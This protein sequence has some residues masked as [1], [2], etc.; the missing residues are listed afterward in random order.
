MPSIMPSRTRTKGRSIV[1]RYGIAAASVAAATLGRFA[2]TPYVGT[3]LPYVVFYFA[4]I[5]VASYLG[6]GPALVA[7]ALAACSAATFF[8]KPFTEFGVAMVTDLIGLALFVAVD[9]VIVGFAEANRRARRGLELEVAERVRAEATILAQIS[10]AEFGRDIGLALTS[11][12]TLAEV[13]DRCAALTI[14][15]LG[16]DRARIATLDELGVKATADEPGREPAADG[17][18]SPDSLRG[19]VGR[20][21]TERRAYLT[22]RLGEDSGVLARSWAIRDDMIA[23]AGCPLVVE[24]RLI[25]VWT[26]LSRTPLDEATTAAMDSAATVL[27]V[28]IE[29]KRADVALRVAKQDAEEANQAK[30]RFLAVLSHELRTPLNPISLTISSILGRPDLDPEFRRDLDLVRHYV[31]LEARMIDDLLDV[32]RIARGKLPLRTE[33]TDAHG[34]VRQAA[35][36]CAEEIA[37]RSL[38]LD[39]DLDAARPTIRVDPSRT[40]QVFWNLIKNAVKFTPIGGAIAIRSRNEP[41]P[42]GAEGLLIEVVDTGIG[43]EPDALP[44]I[45][46]AFQQGDSAITREYGGLGLGLAICQGVVEGHGGTLTVSSA[47]KGR[48]TTFAV[49]LRTAAPGPIEDERGAPRVPVIH[50]ARAAAAHFPRSGEVPP[51][52]E[53]AARAAED[54][55]QVLLVEDEPATIRLMMRLLRGLGYQVTAAATVAEAARHVDGAQRFDLIVSDIGLPDGTGLDLMRRVRAT[56]GELPGIALT[57]FGTD[58]D[59][60]QSRLA[61]FSAHMTKPIDF[62]QLASLIRVVVGP[63]APAG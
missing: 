30:D 54:S 23:L 33:L 9:L 15:H 19:V 1:H 8:I 40:R 17:A 22:N 41:T 37:D 47:G 36:I 24:G 29:R 56:R 49:H 16:G 11:G 12:S 38:G 57:G 32:M 28:G 26:L 39:L 44:R 3:R 63:P 45:F 46:E 13:L 59:I 58:D 43:I 2:L 34:L 61:G 25:G 53:D 20:I 50:A 52:A 27:A 62:A 4:V 31:G 51:R 48:G 42:D 7:I 5:P 10:R 6:V 55:L 21:I 18:A 14:R 60:E 35:A